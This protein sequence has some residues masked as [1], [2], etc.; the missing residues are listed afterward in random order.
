VHVELTEGGQ[1]M[2][3]LKLVGVVKVLT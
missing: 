1:T 2:N 3:N